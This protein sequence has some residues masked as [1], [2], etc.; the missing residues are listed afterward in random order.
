MWRVYIVKTR[1]K[2]I[3]YLLL[4]IWLLHV[5][6]T[7]TI[8]DNDAA[9]PPPYNTSMPLC[10]SFYAWGRGGAWQNRD[11]SR[12]QWQRCNLPSTLAIIGQPTATLFPK[13]FP[14]PLD[15]N[16]DATSPSAIVVVIPRPSLC[17]TSSSLRLE[18]DDDDDDNETTSPLLSR[19]H[20]N[21]DDDNDDKATF[22]FAIDCHFHPASFSPPNCCPRGSITA[23]PR[24]PTI[25]L[26]PLVWL[27][28]SQW[29]S[30]R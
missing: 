6:S 5:A 10:I 21:D 12:Q 24:T 9:G 11:L 30:R 29:R 2:N 17:P 13:S 1:E 7:T 22:S 26:H 16:D 19:P 15:D 3:S 20:N 23:T 4:V 18:D 27:R 28:Q 8:D 14:T 25:P